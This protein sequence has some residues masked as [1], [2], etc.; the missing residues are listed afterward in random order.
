MENYSAV[1]PH[2]MNIGFSI[3]KFHLDSSSFAEK[4]HMILWAIIIMIGRCSLYFYINWPIVT[5]SGQC[6]SGW[7]ICF[8][9]SLHTPAWLRSIRRAMVGIVR[10][11]HIMAPLP[12][13]E[14]SFGKSFL[15]ELCHAKLDAKGILMM[16]ANVQRVDPPSVQ[17]RCL[18][19]LSCMCSCAVVDQNTFIFQKEK[20]KQ[21]LIYIIS[22]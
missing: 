21:L 6:R 11:R 14:L 16:C 10:M 20:T 2:D 17:L 3:G 15:A 18:C 8:W 13:V 22:L 5:T 4:A 19:F 9:E 1:I 12:S 7:W